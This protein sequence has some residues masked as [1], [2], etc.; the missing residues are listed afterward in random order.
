VPRYDVQIRVSLPDNLVEIYTAE[1]LAQSP[2]E[3]FAHIRHRL[4]TEPTRYGVPLTG[5][6]VEPYTQVLSMTI[7][8]VKKAEDAQTLWERLDEE[9]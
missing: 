6:T 1:V 3:V 2:E 8:P 7:D 5:R 9:P 4:S